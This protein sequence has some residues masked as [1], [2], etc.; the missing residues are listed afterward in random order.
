LGLENS[1]IR[2]QASP[3]PFT[4]FYSKNGMGTFSLSFGTRQPTSGYT[5]HNNVVSLGAVRRQVN[6]YDVVNG[7]A[8]YSS[9]PTPNS[10][11][12]FINSITVTTTDHP[13]ILEIVP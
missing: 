10:T 1:I 6:V 3:R 13:V 9:P 11:S 4:H 8:A 12:Y 2:L 7:G 5:T